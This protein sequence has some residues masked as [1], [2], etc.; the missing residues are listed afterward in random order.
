MKWSPT[1]EWNH[2]IETNQISQ[3]SHGGLQAVIA[4]NNEMKNIV[5]GKVVR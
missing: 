1:E 3:I 2:K 4:S 5:D